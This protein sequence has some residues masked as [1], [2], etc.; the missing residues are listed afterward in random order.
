MYLESRNS[1]ETLFMMIFSNIENFEF[2]LQF[3]SFNL[4][5]SEGHPSFPQKILDDSSAVEKIDQG[6]RGWKSTGRIM[7]SIL[8]SEVALPFLVADLSDQQRDR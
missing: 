8:S 6:R 2:K 1:L 5:S 4:L 3:D 7:A